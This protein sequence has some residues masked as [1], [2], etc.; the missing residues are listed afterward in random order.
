M[1]NCAAAPKKIMTGFLKRGVK[2]II[3]PIPIKIRIGNNSVSIPERYS[4]SRNP[5]SKWKA[6]PSL[7]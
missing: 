1:P 7:I 4:T 5:G 6:C 2:S 3:A